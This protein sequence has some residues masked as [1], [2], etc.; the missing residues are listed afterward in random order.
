MTFKLDT[1]NRK[2]DLSYGKPRVVIIGGGVAGM[3]CA[4]WLKQLGLSPEIIE[5]NASLGGELQN[6]DRINRWVLGFQGLS[7]QE[8]AKQYSNHIIE[9]AIPVSFN[10]KLVEVEKTADDFSVCLQ[11]T[12][13]SQ[14]LLS[15]QAI[16][17][18]TGVRTSGADVFSKVLGFSD[19]FAAGLIGCF[20]TD[21][22]GQLALLR[23]KRV[24]VIGGGD[25]AHFTTHD[26]A[27]VTAHTYLLMR[28]P[29]KAQKKIRNEVIELIEQGQV[30][31]FSQVQIVA[32]SQTEAGIELSFSTLNSV[33]TNVIV[34][35]VFVRIGYTANSEFLHAFNYLA[36]IKTLSGGYIETDSERHTSIKS[37][38]AIGDVANSQLQSVVTAIADGAIVARII[39]KDIDNRGELQC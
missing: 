25:N 6:I 26:V 38:Y 14:R 35:R 15:A 37:V 13:A 30:I 20:P 4:L 19:L 2:G 34:D 24:A 31:E 3:S 1:G 11:K 36:N 28:S 18:A 39:A 7:S 22:L 23:G 5:R 21:H 29:P 16:V 17:I 12:D 27:S 33:I 8:L 10:C 32:F 9:E